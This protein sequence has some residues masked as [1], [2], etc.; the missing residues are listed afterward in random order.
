MAD[1]DGDLDATHYSIT[2]PQ[3]NATSHIKGD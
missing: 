2:A 3:A 1:L